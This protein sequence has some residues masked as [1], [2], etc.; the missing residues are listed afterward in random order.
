MDIEKTF[1]NEN[2]EM[3][4][5]KNNYYYVKRIFDFLFSFLALLFLTPLF[6]LISIIIKIDDPK[7]SII[8]F[9]ERVG[10]NGK[11][12]KMYKFRSMYQDAE[13]RL[14]SLL[15]FSDVEGAMFKM[16]NDP[17]ITKVGKFL[18]KYSMDELP[19]LYNVLL[20]D[21]SLVG[22]RPPLPRE[23]I[24]YTKHDKKR[25]LVTP[26]ITGLWQ[27]SGRNSLSFEEMVELDLVYIKTQSAKVDF[28]IL[29]KTVKEVV[30]PMNAF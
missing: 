9:Q 16:H 10:K 25:L 6:L 15:Q 3:S 27:V 1:I 24:K 7:G 4:I 11:L 29:L 18:R 8:F 23:V 21:M 30:V 12:F 22:P 5:K 20:G 26:G 28:V 2:Q 17:R 13:Q 14:E 19:Q